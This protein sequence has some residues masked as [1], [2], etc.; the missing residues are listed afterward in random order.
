MVEHPNGWLNVR[1]SDVRKHGGSGILDRHFNGSLSAALVDVG[2]PFCYPSIL[3]NHTNFHF[4]F[5]GISRSRM[6]CRKVL[7]NAKELLEEPE[8]RPRVLHKFRQR[9]TPPLPSCYLH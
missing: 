4:L 1:A 3:T 7:K 5:Q 8:A 6:E 2:I 9:G